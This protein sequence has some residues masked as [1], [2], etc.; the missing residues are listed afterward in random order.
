MNIIL[1]SPCKDASMQLAIKR[2]D[3]SQNK[4]ATCNKKHWHVSG[5]KRR[6]NVFLVFAGYIDAS[7]QIK[8]PASPVFI[9]S[10]DARTALKCRAEM[11]QWINESDAS[12]LVFCDGAY[13]LTVEAI[14][15]VHVRATNA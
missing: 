14:A 15:D 3:T 6:V 9:I 7:L 1:P 13:S 11:N 4:H 5:N 10:Y 8:I 2:I 12:L